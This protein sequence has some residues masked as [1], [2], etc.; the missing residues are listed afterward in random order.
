MLKRSSF[1]LI[2]LSLVL[3]CMAPARAD[4]GIAITIRDRYASLE[5][6]QAEFTQ[7]LTH[8]ES[9]SKEQR[10]GTLVFKKP[11]LISWQTKK[12]VEEH[13]VISKKEIW[14]YIAD[15]GIAYRYPKEL[16]NDSRSLIQIVTGQAL[17]SQDFDVT[18]T[19][20]E[21]KLVILQLYPKEPVP[22]LVEARLYVDPEKGY[23]QRA[24]ITDFYGNEN[25]VRFT[26]FIP[27][28][29]VSSSV[30]NFTPPKG[31]EVEDRVERSGVESRN[32]F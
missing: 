7:Y 11:L 32:L 12:P 30:F 3:L 18:Q 5:T 22:T 10:E 17:L 28:A 8:R 20:T 26:S 29:S 25:D 13:L 31:V 2:A 9:G 16:V 21:G 24:V 14:D 23:I 27:N 4:E 19:G 6:F 1:L 15:E